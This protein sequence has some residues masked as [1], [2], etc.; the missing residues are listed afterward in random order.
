MGGDHSSFTASFTASRARRPFALVAL[1]AFVL[2]LAACTV[3]SGGTTGGATGTPTATTTAPAATVTVPA[4]TTAGGYKVLV[5]FS[6]KS[7]ATVNH[8]YSVNRVSPTAGVATYAMQQL[9]KGPSASET[10]AGYW[11]E[12]TAA[13]TGA[14]NCGGADFQ[15]IPDQHIDPHTGV[16]SAQPKT[17][18]M[19]FCKTTSLPGDLS[20]GRI[21]T[22]IT[23]TLTQ[24]STITTVQILNSAGHCF[25]D[26]SG[27]DNC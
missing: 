22:Q 12:L 26:L 23:K 15:L 11:T 6:K 7:D 5:Y 24:F 1:G 20:G 4:P 25:D 18:V 9:I 27:Q 16:A 17:W 8:V 19:K 14:S 2:A 21:S 13:L 10:A 3:E